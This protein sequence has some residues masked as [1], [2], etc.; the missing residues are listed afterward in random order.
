MEIPHPRIS[1]REFVLRPLAE[2]APDTI[3][4]VLGKSIKTLL[5]EVVSDQ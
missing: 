1:E 3:H 4:P 2:I 5:E